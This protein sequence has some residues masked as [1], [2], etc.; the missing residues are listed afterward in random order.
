MLHHHRRFAIMGVP[1]M[2]E[3]AEKLTQHTWP[4][5]TCFAYH[6]LLLANDSFSED[7]AQEFAVYKDAHQIESLTVSWMTRA[8]LQEAIE[9][10]LRG[11]YAAYEPVAPLQT[12]PASEH[13][14]R[15]CE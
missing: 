6:G 7:G 13:R 5:C 11:E 4:L 9:A 10:L 2:E 15:L 1:S 12:E 3:L 14:C 8:Q